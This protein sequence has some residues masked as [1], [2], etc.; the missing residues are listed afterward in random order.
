MG[1][2]QQRLYALR[3]CFFC[4]GQTLFNRRRNDTIF[5]N[6]HKTKM[7][8]QSVEVESTAGTNRKIATF[9]HVPRTIVQNRN[10]ATF[11]CLI[12]RGTSSVSHNAS[13]K[14]FTFVWQNV[15][16]SFKIGAIFSRRPFNSFI[17]PPW[18]QQRLKCLCSVPTDWHGI[19]LST[20]NTNTH[21]MPS[22]TENTL[23]H[24]N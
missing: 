9:H 19:L 11:L 12:V 13:E 17:K 22:S 2:N 7:Q 21:M 1:Y 3:L 8:K 6:K 18:M 5:G 15:A 16:F 24:T 23:I 4:G 10:T 20:L 14:S